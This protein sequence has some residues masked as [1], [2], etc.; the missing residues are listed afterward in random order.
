ME[1]HDCPIGRLKPYARN[2]RVASPEAVHRL[3]AA[4]LTFGFRVPILATADGTIVAGHTRLLA[5]K[6]V[7]LSTVP[8]IWCDDMTPDQVRAFRIADN[9]LSSLTDWNPELLESEL[10]DLG[11]ALDDLGEGMGWARD[12]LSALARDDWEDL[13][14]GKT[15]SHQASPFV[16]G[17]AAHDRSQVQGTAVETVGY[18]NGSVWPRAGDQDTKLAPYALSLPRP[19]K[20]ASRY[21]RSPFGEMERI[22]QTY[23]RPGD[24][25]LD[26]C[27]GWWT[28][29][30]TALLHGHQG[31]GI[32]LWDVSIDFGRRQ[33]AR[34]PKEVRQ[35]LTIT[36]GD[37][38]ALPQQDGSFEAAYVNPP[39]HDLEKYGGGS[40]DLAETGSLSAWLTACGR[41]LSEVHRVLKPGGLA[42]TVMTDHR[43]DGV[44]VPVHAD[45]ISAG[46]AAGFVLHDLVV[47]AMISMELRL[48]RKAWDRRRTA[49]AHEYVIVFRKP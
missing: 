2:P 14:G 49:K 1:V 31:E 41:M 11:E 38:R 20:G 35:N 28:F 15:G 13:G 18:D 25:F 33:L 7:G 6:D 3:G 22:V 10:R 36:R 43:R 24:R 23:M 40:D 17:H 19:T 37:A 26:V 16:G 42:I 48:W 12:E 44:L 45:W 4:M 39:F 30:C 46:R 21:S 9:K 8:V 5:A 34:L 27:A 29:S 32:D 47:Q